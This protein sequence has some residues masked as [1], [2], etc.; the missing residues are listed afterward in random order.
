MPT[1]FLLITFCCWGIFSAGL[2][3]AVSVSALFLP[4]SVVKTAETLPSEPTDELLG[5][6]HVNDSINITKA[7]D[8]N[9]DAY[10]FVSMREPVSAQQLLM[11]GF[12][13]EITMKTVV[14]A[15]KLAIKI[16]KQKIHN[17]K[18]RKSD[19]KTYA[20][21]RVKHRSL[22][23]NSV[24]DP[25]L[26]VVTTP[27]KRLAKWVESLFIDNY[28]NCQFQNIITPIAAGNVIKT[29]DYG[30][31]VVVN[32][33]LGD[34]IMQEALF[35]EDGKPQVIERK[36]RGIKNIVIEITK[37]KRMAMI[38]DGVHFKSINTKNPKAQK[39]VLSLAETKSILIERLLLEG[40]S[41]DVLRLYPEEREN[42]DELTKKFNLKTAALH[43]K[44]L[45]PKE[46]PVKT[47]PGKSPAGKVPAK[48]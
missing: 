18:W 24:C 21:V 1:K 20:R 39:I 28:K 43:R 40:R 38:S 29:K 22:P 35:K 23:A 46:A 12:S 2:A 31:A 37:E 30:N 15:Q 48:K 11:R 8:A 25:N 26:K 6:E 32:Y 36:Y 45:L 27:E 10:P 9:I 17:P 34:R 44:D 5:I 7:D 33:I 14:A 42:M 47:A 41:Q 4:D 16:K 3:K 19:N 13:T